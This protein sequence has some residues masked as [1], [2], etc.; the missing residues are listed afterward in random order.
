MFLGND[1][2]ETHGA[3]LIQ[4]T[5]VPLE[6]ENEESYSAFEEAH[7]ENEP[8]EEE[9]LEENLSSVTASNFTDEVAPTDVTPT[10]NIASIDDDREENQDLRGSVTKYEGNHSKQPISNLVVYLG[11][12]IADVINNRRIDAVVKIAENEFDILSSNRNERLSKLHKLPR[13]FNGRYRSSKV[14]KHLA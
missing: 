3:E 11:K 13:L 2:L 14:K 9:N 10:H 1:Y 5:M 4:Q 6:E 12:Y 7:H 8:I